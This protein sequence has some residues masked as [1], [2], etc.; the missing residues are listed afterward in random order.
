MQPG[1]G[2]TRRTSYQTPLWT[3]R[4]PESEVLSTELTILFSSTSEDTVH[5]WL[6]VAHMCAS[7][8]GT[9]THCHCRPIDNTITCLFE[10]SHKVCCTL[11]SKPVAFST[12]C[13]ILKFMIDVPTYWESGHIVSI[14]IGSKLHAW[15]MQ[16]PSCHTYS[17]TKHTLQLNVEY[18]ILSIYYM[19]CHIYHIN[20][21]SPIDIT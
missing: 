5:Q 12:T 6:L 15:W 18:V 3:L 11:T 1:S 10:D 21:M 14:E 8:E 13:G 19:I 4:S 17:N 20:H 9:C 7:E 2:W 16:L